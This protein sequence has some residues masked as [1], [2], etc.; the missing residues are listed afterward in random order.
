MPAANEPVSRADETGKVFL[1]GMDDVF[2]G[3]LSD[4]SMFHALSLALA[5]AANAGVSNVEFLTHRGATLHDLRQR[6]SDSRLVPA[7]STL[8]AMLMII[9]YEVS[10]NLDDIGVDRANTL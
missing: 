2:R 8:T 5:L 10:I 3:A 4:P 9:G 1:N 7:V 6:M